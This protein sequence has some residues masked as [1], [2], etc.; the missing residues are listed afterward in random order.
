MDEINFKVKEMTLAPDF[1]EFVIEPLE[2]GYGHTIGNALRR[3]LYT[4]IQGA[5]V[6]SVRITGVKH[7]FSTL[8]GLK[9]NIVDLLLNI[10]DLNLKLEGSKDSAT[11]KLSAK[12]TK[13]ITAADLESTDGVEVV[14]KE[15]YIGSLSGDKAK[16]DMELTVEK[17]YGFSLAEERRASTLGVMTID[18]VFTPV[19]RVTY[20]VSA[21]R[22]GRRTDLDKLTVKIWTNGTVDPKD[23]LLHAA[24]LLSAYFMQVYEPKEVAAP[25]DA[26]AASSTVPQ[27]LLNMTIDE[28]D[29][30]TRIY[31]SLRNG[32]IETIEQL[33]S[34]PR[35]E[36]V[37]M[38]NMGGKSISVIEEKLGEKGITL[39]V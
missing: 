11:I 4:S 38:R 33:L 32:G 13:K 37:S 16:L 17:G 27:N 36:L 3:V 29:L 23:A 14:D 10:K 25:T 26:P 15:Q 1:G 18:A 35:K 2:P 28:L 31:N 7:K 20:E 19:R 24:K 6:T 22:V 39:N 12:G 21:T 34:T 30:P 8:P 9:E 5:A